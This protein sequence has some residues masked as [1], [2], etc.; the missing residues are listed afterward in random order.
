MLF[1][2][3][4]TKPRGRRHVWHE[5]CLA[6]HLIL[7]DY[8]PFILPASLMDASNGTGGLHGVLG[9]GWNRRCQHRGSVVSV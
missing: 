5:A 1:L 8:P 2:P 4:N 6:G 3:H 9:T 7:S